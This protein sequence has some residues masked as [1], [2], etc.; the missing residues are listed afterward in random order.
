MFSTTFSRDTFNQ[1]PVVGILRGFS[2]EQIRE[3]IPV[4]IESGFRTVEI[5]M[6][7]PNVEESIATLAKEYP[8]LNVGAG[9]VCNMAD[10]KRALDA[11]SQFIVT[12]ILDEEVVRYCVENKIPVFP[13]AY[14]PTEIYKAWALGANAVKIFPATQ[15]GTRYIKD[16]LGPLNTIKENIADFFKVGC[17]GV[18]M[19][20]SLFD[21]NII[22]SGDKEAL[23]KHFEAIKQG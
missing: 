4:Y 7:S 19:G 6:N 12:P 13:G 16:I 14:T 5:T 8:D 2:M 18:G 23:K 9:T 21:K 20:G 17:V 3:I 15:L 10:L 1:T 11:G 22:L